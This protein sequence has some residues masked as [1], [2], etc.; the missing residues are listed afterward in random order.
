MRR[1]LQWTLAAAG[2]FALLLG[3]CGDQEPEER[4]EMPVEREAG[5]P[6]EQPGARPEAGPGQEQPDQR[7]AEGEQKPSEQQRMAGEGETRGGEAGVEQEQTAEQEQQEQ[8]AEHFAED[9][10]TPMAEREGQAATGTDDGGQAGAETE[11][12]RER[13]EG[14]TQVARRNLESVTPED[15]E[16]PG[17]VGA[18]GAAGAGAAAGAAAAGREGETARSQITD[19]GPEGMTFSDHRKAIHVVVTDLDMTPILI[20]STIMATAEGSQTLLVRNDALRERTLRITGLDVEATLPPGEETEVRLPSLQPGAIHG[21]EII[22][23]GPEA[24]AEAAAGAQPREL[25]S[26]VVLPGRQTRAAGETT[27]QPGQTGQTGQTQQGSEGSQP[28]SVSSPPPSQ[29]SGTTSEGQQPPGTSE[30]G[31]ADTGTG[32][33]TDAGT[34]P[35][36]EGERAEPGGTDQPSTEAAPEAEPRG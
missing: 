1:N 31:T 26:I 33:G 27:G 14:T 22:E 36:T 18:A 25:A 5:Q 3:G 19:A 7:A 34:R 9:M 23:P 24:T 15:V 6:E 35:P 29:E 12:A 17:A 16:Q 11:G 30:P 32:T 4:G 20:P 10:P 13:A 2:V 21:I 28:P 8:S